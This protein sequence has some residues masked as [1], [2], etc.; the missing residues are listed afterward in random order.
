MSKREDGFQVV[1]LIAVLAI[2]GML[3]LIGAPG[4]LRLSAGLRV[5]LAAQELSAALRS[6]R[7][8]AI[9]N[10]RKAGIKFRT[11]E[12]GHV[13]FTVY[14]DGDD[15][16]VRT[17]DIRSGVD[18]QLAPTRRLAHLGGQIRLG[19]PEGRRPRDPG[20]SR[21]WMD[22]LDDPVRFNRSDIASFG[23]LGQSTPGSLYLT[24]GGRHLVVVR[25][26]GGTGK[27]RTLIYD[28]QRERW[29]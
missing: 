15:D 8:L 19:F 6:A 10:N 16:G 22:R 28:W 29:R 14:G 21:R 4:L 1:E 18:P 11:V 9:R 25:L 26:Y 7:S 24:D 17:A 3:V 20:D 2:T 27:V 5:R 23:A 13:T 12:S